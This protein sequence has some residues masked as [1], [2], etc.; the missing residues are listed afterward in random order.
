[1]KK[2][3]GLTL[4]ILIM[5]YT[6]AFADETAA[7]VPAAPLGLTVNNVWMMVATFLVFIMHLGFASLEAGLTRS[8]NTVNILF[9][10]TLIPA[11]GLLTYAFF[12]FNLMYPG[13]F[14]GIFGFSGFGL[15]FPTVEGGIWTY[16]TMKVIPTGQIFFFRECSQ[17]QQLL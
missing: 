12:G 10:N 8:K 15:P 13:A 11:I 3:F 16:L 4:T 14:N 5:L 9:K 7:A 1:M 2:I 6:A 17:L